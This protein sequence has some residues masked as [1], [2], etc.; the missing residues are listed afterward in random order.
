MPIKHSAAKYPHVLISDNPGILMVSRTTRSCCIL[1]ASIFFA[2]CDRP[3]AAAPVGKEKPPAV[4]RALAVPA[5]ME[6]GTAVS[7]RTSEFVYSEK[8]APCRHRNPL[9]NVHFGDLHVHSSYSF[10]AYGNGTRTK[11]EDAYRFAQGEPIDLPPYDDDGEPLKQVRLDHPL[12]FMAVTDHAEYF[13]EMAVCLD[14]D[15]PN[16]K[17]KMCTELRQPGYESY[18][19]MAPTVVLQTPKRMTE[20]CDRD[21][22]T[23]ERRIATL[24]G[25]TQEAAE[26]AYDRTE[27]CSFTSFV[28]Y[29]YSGVPRYRNLHRN[30]I[31][32][33]HKVPDKPISYVEA[34]KD[35]Q[36]WEQL[37]RECVVKIEGCD[38][39]AIPHNPNLSNA[40]LLGPIKGDTLEIQRRRAA[41]RNATEPLMEIFQHK[42]NSECMNG[43]SGILGEPDELCEIEQ[44]RKIGT[45]SSYKNIFAEV[46]DCEGDPGFLGLFNGGCVAYNDFF[47]GAA[48][49]GLKEEQ[50]LGINPL[51]MGVIGSTDTHVGAAGGTDETSWEGHIV[52]ETSLDRRLGSGYLPSNLNGNPG[53]LAGVWAIENSR[54]A[55]FDALKRRETFGT[56]GTRIVPRFFAAWDYPE[57]LCENPDMI[58]QAYKLGVPMGSDL[59]AQ[60]GSAKT[61]TFIAAAQRDASGNSRPLKKMQIIKGWIDHKGDANYRVFDVAGDSETQLFQEDTGKG[62]NYLCTVFNDPEFNPALPAYYYLR[63]VEQASLRWSAAQCRTLSPGQRP[64]ACNND[65]PEIIHELAWTS[66]IWYRAGEHQPD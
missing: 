31:F 25:A 52:Y 21:G 36:L 26:Q 1:L 29:E 39:L 40:D 55:L 12:D 58:E 63:V 23:C 19:P 5:E 65:A 37:Q 6:I 30:V 42:G 59:P 61:V 3:A 17:T 43:L 18:V 22:E 35:Y 9:R 41:L 27:E 14:P 28:G 32:R 15:E 10:D 20:I 48:L 60:P 54:D 34:P 64:A 11:P 53:G 49:L 56:S 44:I 47:R 51:K 33:N 62:F 38:V 2:A 50:R 8:H 16:Y 66:P 24:W 7:D 46:I 45:Y 13:G 4:V 57:D